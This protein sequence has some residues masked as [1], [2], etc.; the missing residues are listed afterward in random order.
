MRGKKPIPTA[1]KETQGYFRKHPERRNPDEPTAER[2]FPDAPEHIQDDPVAFSKWE[3]VCNLLDEM[4][5]LT[6]ADKDI[7]ALFCETY[8]I[9]L[10]TTI[11]LRKHGS[12][13][14]STKGEDIPSVEAGQVHRYADRM[15]K[16]LVELGLTP[17]SRSR[18][19][20]T[21]TE[22]KDENPFGSLISRMGGNN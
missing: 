7:L 8:S 9:W 18:V 20:K 21:Q 10:K 12:S 19:K 15:L 11:H 17:S 16:I 1:I 13:R 14:L 22:N 2:G 4:Q 5:V 6:T 3:E